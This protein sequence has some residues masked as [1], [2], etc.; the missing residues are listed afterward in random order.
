MI[1]LRNILVATDFGPASVAA[2][3][4]GRELARTF[5]AALHVLHALENVFMHPIVSD[6]YTVE[7][8]A[9][10]RLAALLGPGTE[11]GQGEPLHGRAVV[12]ITDAPAEAIVRYARA[13]EIDLIIVGTHGRQRLSRL[14]LGSVAEVVVRTAPCPVLTIHHPE[15][16][17][18]LQSAEPAEL[19]P[20]A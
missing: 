13:A 2:L 11:P 20:P 3:T 19:R 15:H 7:A 14:L 17:F 9:R 6:P 4:Y 8:A 18:I 16:E 1:A 5:G 10:N 12:D